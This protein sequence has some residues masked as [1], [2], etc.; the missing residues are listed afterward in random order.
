M[1]YVGDEL[2]KPFSNLTEK[3]YVPLAIGFWDSSFFGV[4]ISEE[5]AIFRFI[6]NQIDHSAIGQCRMITFFYCVCQITVYNF[7]F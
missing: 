3:S 7:N 1:A 2:P 5:I 6:V 4:A